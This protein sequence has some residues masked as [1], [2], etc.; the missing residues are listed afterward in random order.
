MRRD[1]F[2]DGFGSS[3]RVCHDGST[4]GHRPAPQPSPP[5]QHKP[6]AVRLQWHS[7]CELSIRN[8]AANVRQDRWDRGGEGTAAR[9]VADGSL[10]AALVMKIGAD[11]RYK[12]CHPN[13]PS[14]HDRVSDGRH[15][16]GQTPQ[17]VGHHCD[18]LN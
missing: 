12:H 4:G 3:A 11:C 16:Q 2:P 17:E 8:D 15:R 1:P 18:E 9:S 13:R 5:R 6:D 14:L 10:I 7:L